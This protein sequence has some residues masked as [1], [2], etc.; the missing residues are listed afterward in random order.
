MTREARDSTQSSTEVR[1]TAKVE[2]QAVT[3][4][5]VSARTGE[6]V[7]ALTP[8]TLDVRQG[9]FLAIVGPSGCGK[10]TLLK[11][12][13]GIETLSSGR[14][15]VDGRVISGP[16]PERVLVFQQYALFPWKTVRENIEFGLRAAGIPKAERDRRVDRH[17][18]MVGLRGFETR[19]PHELSGGMQQRCA[20]ARALVVDPKVLLMDEPL[21]AVDAQTR[22]LLQEEL[23][24]LWGQVKPAQDR[25][26]VV[27]VTHNIDEAIYL[28]DRV[29]VMSARPGSIKEI[30]DVD[31]DRPRTFHTRTTPE[32]LRLIERTWILI[33]QEIASLGSE[34]ETVSS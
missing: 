11:M 27:Y 25:K 4:R 29:V 22:V 18:D 1:S 30:I 5:Y 17:I 7:E 28:A 3:K 8:V 13:A 32:C 26:S 33:R 24:D 2:V 31:L 15:L 19:Y 21:A 23:L 20:L 16:S 10:S 9:E 34:V 12:V 6:Q 14:I